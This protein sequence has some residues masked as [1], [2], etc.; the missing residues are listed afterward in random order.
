MSDHWGKKRK[1]TQN[2]DMPTA[3][4]RL[5][6]LHAHYW[7]Y[8]V[9]GVHCWVT[10]ICWRLFFKIFFGRYAQIPWLCTPFGSSAGAERL[11]LLLNFLP[12]H[13]NKVVTDSCKKNPWNFFFIISTCSTWV[14][15]G[16]VEVIT[17]DI[18][19]ALTELTLLIAFSDILENFVTEIQKMRQGYFIF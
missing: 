2:F 10:G 9:L 18:L 8:H 7:F 11:N 5:K 14:Q 19:Q 1:T 15:I 13:E 3:L 4:L 6:F 16:Y 17:L 12:F